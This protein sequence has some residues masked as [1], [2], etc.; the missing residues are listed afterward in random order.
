MPISHC[1]NYC[2]DTL[3]KSSYFVRKPCELRKTL[4]NC[5]FKSDDSTLKRT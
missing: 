1:L 3:V 5:E 4:A 2:T